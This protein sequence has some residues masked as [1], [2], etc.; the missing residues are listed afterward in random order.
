MEELGLGARVIIDKHLRPLLTARM[1]KHYLIE[2][3]LVP[4]TYEDNTT[5][6]KAVNLS[7]EIHGLKIAEQENEGTP[8]RAV[9][10]DLSH[11]PPQQLPPPMEPPDISKPG[12]MP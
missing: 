10:L 6:F 12:A 4:R 11:R 3:K 7:M 1:T 2:G 9:V 8:I 5:R